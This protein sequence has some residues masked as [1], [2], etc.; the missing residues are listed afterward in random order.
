M[1]PL[2]REAEEVAKHA[3]VGYGICSA[4]AGKGG[5]I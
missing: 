3:I 4:M 1:A 2:D 5:A